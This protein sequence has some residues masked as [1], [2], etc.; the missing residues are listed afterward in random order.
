MSTRSVIH[1]HAGPGESSAIL[2]TVYRHHDGHP[3]WAGLDLA[4]ALCRAGSGDVGRSALRLLGVAAAAQ[5]GRRRQSLYLFHAGDEPGDVE[6][7]YDVHPSREGGWIVS[8]RGANGWHV[9]RRERGPAPVMRRTW[10]AERERLVRA[11]L[12]RLERQRM[13]SLPGVFTT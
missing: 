11:Y 6:Y 12:Q 7:V 8:V 3:A 4:R 10:H 2:A 13:Q 9:E 1:L 5:R